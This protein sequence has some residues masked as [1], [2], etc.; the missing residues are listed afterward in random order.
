MPAITTATTVD[1]PDDP[2]IV[3]RLR[4]GSVIYAKVAG[5]LAALLDMATQQSA[6]WLPSTIRELHGRY[7]T[8]MQTRSDEAH[9]LRALLRARRADHLLSLLI[10]NATPDE[11]SVIRGV[12]LR[13][14]LLIRC[15][16]GCYNT[17]AEQHC[18]SCKALV[19]RGG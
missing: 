16:C 10:A 19:V 12:A 5:D 11:A 6:E 13:A 3:I 9:R 17:A 15:P 2:N 14:G 1:Q 7:V 8:E 18:T 4:T